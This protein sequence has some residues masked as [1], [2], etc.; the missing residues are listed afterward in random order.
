[1][2]PPWE[3]SQ[4]SEEE[5]FTTRAPIIAQQAGDKRKQAIAALPKTDPRLWAAYVSESQRIAASNNFYR[6]SGRFAL[7]AVGKLNTYPLFAET[8]SQLVA[9]L[10]RAGFI[11][12]TGIA[13]DDS[14]KAYFSYLIHNALLV[15]LQA[16]ENEE[17]IF[18][19]VHHSFRF[20]MLTLGKSNQAEFVFF[21]RQPSQIHDPR[22][23]F[24]LT[25]DEF[26][27]L[28]PNTLTCPV[29]RSAQDAELTKKLYRAAPVLIDDAR[30]D[31]NPWGIRF[32]QGL[33]NMTSDS[34]L[35]AD[36]PGSGRLPLYEAKMIHQFDHR[37]ATYTPDGDSRDVTLAEHR[38][39]N[40]TVTPRY[41]VDAAEV[42]QRLADKG[43]TRGWL[44]GWRDITSAHVL[45]TV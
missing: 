45:R 8:M 26:R 38:D 7:S 14:T 43:W 1:G 15:R 21:A 23:L 36:A 13:T 37:W 16:F 27:L 17:F 30:P 41:W 32:S 2:N 9:P 6:E 44:M 5:F 29:F 42:E 12:P 35:F 31:G 40:F 39:P 4:M 20:C 10:G 34:H 33:F 25:P 19:S 18:P 28:N 24:R 11:V 3:V 22:R